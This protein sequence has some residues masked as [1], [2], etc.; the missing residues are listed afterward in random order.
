M[1]VFLRYRR[2]TLSRTA[3]SVSSQRAD[4]SG[5]ASTA[6]PRDELRAEIRHDGFRLLVVAA[7]ERVLVEL[8][9]EPGEQARAHRVQSGDDTGVGRLALGELGERRPAGIGSR[10]SV[11]EDDGRRHAD[12]H[13]GRQVP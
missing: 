8:V 1:P 9:V 2:L 10:A 4:S 12:D 13:L 6:R 7:V 5:P 11:S 3:V